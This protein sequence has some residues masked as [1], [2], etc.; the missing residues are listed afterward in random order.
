[1]RSLPLCQPPE[2]SCGDCRACCVAFPFLP[3]EGCWPEGKG[4]HEPCRFVC[5]GGCRIHEEP[6]PSSCTDF[7]CAYL[8]GMFP[9]GPDQCG[10]EMGSPYVLAVP[11]GLDTMYG[12]QIR[13]ARS[14]LQRDDRVSRE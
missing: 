10:V 14:D 13:G 6:R 8:A 4:A 11:F 2:R 7:V 1:V 9:V 12:A 5:A 3:E